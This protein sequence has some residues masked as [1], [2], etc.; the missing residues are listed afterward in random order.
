MKA[1]EYYAK[2]KEQNPQTA[3]EMANAIGDVV[4]GLN[5][6][7]KELIKKR[8]ITRG[9]GCRAIIRELNNK[10]NAIVTLFEKDYG[11]S[12]IKR[13]RFLELWAEKIPELAPDY[14]KTAADDSNR[15]VFDLDNPNCLTTLAMLGSAALGEW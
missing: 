4:D 13:N 15:V 10:W 3:K 11:V 14:G 1:K 2:I 6:E 7:A 5:N 12:P 9:D 8:H